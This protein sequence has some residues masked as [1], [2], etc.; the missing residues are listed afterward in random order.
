MADSVA[1]DRALAQAWP[2]WPDYA[3]V[4]DLLPTLQD[5]VARGRRYA[6]ATL[7]DVQGSA[8]RPVGAEMAVNQ[9]G[10]VAGY[11]SGGCVEAAVA[12]EARAALIDGQVRMLDYGAGSPVLDLQLS[13]GGRIRILVR[14]LVDGSAHV[15]MLAAARQARRPLALA[16]DLNSGATQAA[17]TAPAGLH[18]RHF[19][20]I[21][22][23]PRRLVVVG[24]DPVALALLRHAPGFGIE[25]VLLRPHGPESLPASLPA[26]ALYDRRG[27]ET[28]LA[29]LRLDRY[30]AVYSVSHDADIDHTVLTHAL[31][32][33]AYC[34]GALGSR[35]KAE[36]KRQRLRDAGFDDAAMTRLHTPAGLYIGARTPNEIALSILGQVVADARH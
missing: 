8:P 9:D 4:D 34:I 29:D 14:P 31:C 33:D 10:D 19:V 15:A 5:W 17:G 27:L 12:A 16:I 20:Q 30:C 32:S 35:T 25:V 22:T 36:Q 24:G 7:I 6:L 2:D 28:A 11:V 1:S 13:C 26:P 23:P 18:A 21:Y 3:L